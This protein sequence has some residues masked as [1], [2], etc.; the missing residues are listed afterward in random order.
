[1]TVSKPDFP[2]FRKRPDGKTY[3]KIISGSEFEEIKIF[4]KKYAIL[5]TTCTKYP[6]KLYIRELIYLTHSIECMNEGEYSDILEYCQ[7]K[8]IKI[9]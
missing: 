3:Y 9:D 8:L 5:H 2:L 6:E 4:G 1:M 7:S